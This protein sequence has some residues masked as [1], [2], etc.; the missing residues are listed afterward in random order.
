MDIATQAPG[1]RRSA[2][3]GRLA[4]R[5]WTDDPAV[6]GAVESAQFR[7]ATILGELRDRAEFSQEQTALAAGLLSDTVSRLERMAVDPQL[8]TLVRLA[9]VFGYELVISVRPRRP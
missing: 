6:R 5:R 7:V 1:E 4:G 8:S 9:L 2:G 3:R